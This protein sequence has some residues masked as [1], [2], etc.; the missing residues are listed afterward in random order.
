MVKR[1]IT[2]SAAAI[3]LWMRFL[4]RCGCICP[5]TDTLKFILEAGTLS[6]EKSMGHAMFTASLV[7]ALSVQHRQAWLKRIS[8]VNT[9]LEEKDPNLKKKRKKKKQA[10]ND[11]ICTSSFLFR[12]GHHCTGYEV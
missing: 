12:L 3:L 6:G 5:S 2:K 10:K 1:A 4:L 7:V 9:E 8:S 11:V